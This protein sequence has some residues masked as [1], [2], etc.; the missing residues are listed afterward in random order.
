M[1]TN[2]ARR[3]NDRIFCVERFPIVWSIRPVA[4]E[5]GMRVLRHYYYIYGFKLCTSFLHT[6]ETVAP[7]Y[8]VVR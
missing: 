5:P 7:R 8:R 4:N 1:T 3:R 2:E 6:S